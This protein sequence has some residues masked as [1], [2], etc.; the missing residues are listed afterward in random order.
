MKKLKMMKQSFAILPA[1]L[2]G[3]GEWNLMSH[4][5]MLYHQI[6]HEKPIYGG[7]E[8]RASFEIAKNTQTY[9]LNMFHIYGDKDDVIKTRSRY[10]W[11]IT[12]LII[13]I[14]NT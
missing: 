1:P 10:S 9:F 5:V 3:V 8:S 13:S 6:H 2:G 4:P 11:L 14:S 12:F 7:Y